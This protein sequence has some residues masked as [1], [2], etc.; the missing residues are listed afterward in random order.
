MFDIHFNRQAGDQGSQHNDN[1]SVDL[2][3]IAAAEE[4]RRQ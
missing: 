4:L 2:L 3:F 1:H